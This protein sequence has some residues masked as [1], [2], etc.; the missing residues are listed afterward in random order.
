MR[1]TR[2]RQPVRWYRRGFAGSCTSAMTRWLDRIPKLSPI[3]V[4][5][6]PTM[7]LS[8]RSSQ[9]LLGASPEIFPGGEGHACRALIQLMRHSALAIRDAVTLERSELV[10]DAKK[11]IYRVATARQKTGTHVSV[12]LPPEIAAEVLA[13]LNGNP[14]LCSGTATGWNNPPSRIGS[15]T[16]APCSALRSGTT[17]TL[18]RIVCATQRRSNG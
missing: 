16:S 2:H 13:V 18:R 17:R 4:D 1:S 3:K 11:K 12:P 5:E 8:R 9:K 7:P 6:P 15:T 10:H 14:A